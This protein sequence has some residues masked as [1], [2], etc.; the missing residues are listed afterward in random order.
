MRKV[1][2]THFRYFFFLIFSL[3]VAVL[4]FQLKIP[5]KAVDDVSNVPIKVRILRDVLS[6]RQIVESEDPQT[7]T[8]PKTKPYL[9]DKDRSFDRQTKA[10]VVDKFQKS[11]SGG[12]GNNALS[13]GALG[14]AAPQKNPF[15]KAAR[16][17]AQAKRENKSEG[18]GRV[19]SSTNDHIEDIPVGD[20]THL[21]TVEY[22]FYGYFY[23]IKQ[24]LE[25]FWGRSVQEK[26]V[27]LAGEGRLVSDEE[28]VTALRIVMNEAGEIVDVII[29]GSSGVRELDDAAIES[30][31][32]AG[33]FPN[34]PKDLI[35]RGRVTIEWGF[36]VSS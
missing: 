25:G 10:R 9:S 34:P 22:K 21:N 35:V 13:L 32:D 20:L 8:I 6:T 11:R 33:P 19:F 36:V 3:H 4:F 1:I 15:E 7:M 24:K 16:E 26:A 18:G 14:D 31:N 30:F 17:Y 12:L 2:K 23:R 27:I 5:G 28:L 29:L